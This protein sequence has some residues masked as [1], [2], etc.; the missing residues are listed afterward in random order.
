MTIGDIHWIELPLTNGRE[1]A[2]HRPAVIVQDETYAGDLPF[3][4]EEI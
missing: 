1:Q 2:G 4:N 3:C